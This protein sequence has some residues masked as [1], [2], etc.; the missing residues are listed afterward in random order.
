M[1]IDARTLPNDTLIEG[2]LCI[3]GTGPA[4]LSIAM[5]W[6]N[7]PYKVILLEG[8][9]MEYDDQTQDLYDGRNT[10]LPY[11]PLRS[12]HLHYFG[13]TSGHWG[14]FCSNFDE[15]DFEQ[16]SWV[17]YSGWPIRK[18]DLDPFYA[19]AHPILDLGPCEYDIS[20]WQKKDAELKTVLPENPAV[21]NK[22]WQFS[23]PTRFGKKYEADIRKSNNIHAYTYANVTDIRTNENVSSVES[24]TIK[25]FAGKQHKVKARQVIV[26]CGAISNARLLLACNHQ[27]PRGLG[28]DNDVVGRYFM[29]HLETKSAFL[30]LPFRDPLKMYLF[31]TGRTK[32]RCEL[33]LSRE[34]QAQHGILN[35]VTSLKSM[36]EA[37]ID[38]PA[39]K[40]WTNTDPQ[41]NGKV[42]FFRDHLARTISFVDRTVGASK[43]MLYTRLEQAP[44][45]N[46]RVTLDGVN[47]ALGMPKAVL[48]WELTALERRS[49]RTFYELVGRQFGAAGCGRVQ[50]MDYLEDPDDAAWPDFAGGGWHHIGTTRMSD[51]PKMGVVDA[52][53]KVH[54][55]ANLHVAGSS[56]FA[57]SGS[58]NPTLTLVA[59]SLRLSDHL[60][61]LV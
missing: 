25:N 57:T 15:I 8:G 53:C 41:K 44:N 9:G 18:A 5:E 42:G 22:I 24:L 12:T 11:F 6:N 36:S 1:F 7:T 46:S 26:A 49:M 34:M 56:C 43:F 33:S 4:G 28:N 38:N 16:R 35:G 37:N 29:D 45:P 55:I 20:Y 13:G 10:G 17:P 21:W 60:K 3:I 59:L 52:N 40:S 58:A 14:G 54:G 51:D 30:H 39:M 32:M 47:D 2:D 50:L 27:A 23:T 61:K 31:T 48:H 19:R